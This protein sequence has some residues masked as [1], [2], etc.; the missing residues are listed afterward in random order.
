MGK[1]ERA[2]ESSNER[3]VQYRKKTIRSSKELEEKTIQKKNPLKRGGTPEF[4]IILAQIVL[5][6]D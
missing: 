2:L 3:N 1:L 4:H 6:D 5:P